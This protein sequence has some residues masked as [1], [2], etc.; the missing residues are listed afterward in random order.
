MVHFL[1]VNLGLLLYANRVNLVRWHSMASISRRGEAWRAMVRRRGQTLTRTFD[2]EA[3][4]EAWAIAEEARII[5]GATAAQIK[6]TPSGT[7]VASLFDRY[8]REVSPQKDGGRWEI[9]RLA[10]LAPAFPMAA[11]ELDGAAVAE[12]RDSRLREVSPSSV[13]RELNLISAVLTRAI[14]EWR[15]PLAANP[16]HM[17]ARPRMPHAR[18]RRVSGAER[19]AILERLGWDGA[20]EPATLNQWVAWTFCVALETMM[21]Q[22]ELLRLTWEHV[23]LD[24]KFCHLPKTKNGHPRNVPLSSKAV[25]LFNLLTVRDATDR[26]VPV[27]AGTFGIYFREAVK[28]AGIDDL[29]F[30]DSRR[31]ALTQASK[32][33]SNVAELARASGHRTTR[34]LMAYYE[35]D[36]TDLADKLG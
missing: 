23:H 17:V 35:P 13:N 7:T 34:A 4:A 28:L 6:K 31:E 11:I 1:V 8:A 16:V 9:I 14:K 22:G 33:L 32:K 24:R 25:A 30:H 19:V 26:V 27:S 2:T 36:A 20:S 29:H 12:W 15:L 21:R 18:R 5:G 10:K 3:Q